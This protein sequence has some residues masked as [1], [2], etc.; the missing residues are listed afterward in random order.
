MSL[1]FRV[2]ITPLR[3]Q[4]GEI[5]DGEIHA[6]GRSIEIPKDCQKRQPVIGGQEKP[7]LTAGFQEIESNGLE[8]FQ[9]IP[10]YRKSDVLSRKNHLVFL[11]LI[12]CHDQRS[13]SAGSLREDSDRAGPFPVFQNLLN[14]LSRFLCDFYHDFTPGYPLNL[15]DFFYHRRS[16]DSVLAAAIS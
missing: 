9:K 16:L 12:Q 2:L 6:S 10:V 14:H 7:R 1:V 3:R 4:G 13:P 5:A 8:F 15:G 11:G